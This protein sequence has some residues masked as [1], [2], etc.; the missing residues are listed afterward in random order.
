MTLQVD[1]DTCRKVHPELMTFEKWAV[2]RGY[3]DK[4]FDKP[5]LCSIQ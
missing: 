3:P 1:I 4:K 2:K 5:G